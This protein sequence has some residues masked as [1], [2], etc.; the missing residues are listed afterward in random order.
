MKWLNDF[1]LEHSKNV[2]RGRSGKLKL[3][4]HGVLSRHVINERVRAVI[5]RESMHIAGDLESLPKHRIVHS[6][7]KLER[8]LVYLTVTVN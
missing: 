7:R 2:G 1:M 4:C 3:F 5:A 8:C 6:P